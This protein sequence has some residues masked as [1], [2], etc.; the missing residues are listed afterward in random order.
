MRPNHT[1]RGTSYELIRHGCDVYGALDV[2]GKFSGCQQEAKQKYHGRARQLRDTLA[3][4]MK[5]NQRLKVSDESIA[6]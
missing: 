3:K 2:I 6:I 4:E 5:L 1:S